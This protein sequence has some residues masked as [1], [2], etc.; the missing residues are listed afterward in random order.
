MIYLTNLDL[1]AP[2][3]ETERIEVPPP[4]PL[5]TSRY[6]NWRESAGVPIGITVGRPRFVRYDYVSISHLAPHELFRAP[7]K[8]IDNIPI[9][10]R[11]YRERLRVFEPEILEALEEVARSY[12]DLPGV[13][14]C[15]EDVNG[16]EACHR[17]WASEWFGQRFGW[18]VP[19]LPDPADAA[20]RQPK[21]R[22][23]ATAPA[24]DTLF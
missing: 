8:N 23:P 19:E 15:F 10:R 2:E 1:N 24:P 7:F 4:L 3:P 22:K 6:Q 18:N 16:G 20:P 17:Q 14:M 9:E 5:A 21:G 12:P 11:V 13:L